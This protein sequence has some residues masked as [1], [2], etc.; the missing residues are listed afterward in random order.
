MSALPLLALNQLSS[1][2]G[3]PLVLLHA[4]PVDSRMWQAVAA[5]L[6]A[7]VRA[8]AADLPGQG[9]SPL[10]SIQTSM[11]ETAEAVYRTLKNEGIANAI[12]VGCSMGGYVAL[13]LAERHPAFVAGLGLVDTK[14]TADSADVR[15]YRLRMAREMEMGPTIAPA[16]AMYAS[17]LGETTLKERRALIPAVENWVHSQSPRGLAWA[18][19]T[20]AG[21]LD[22]TEMLRHY[23]GPVAVVLGAEDKATTVADAQVMVEAAQDVTLEVIP[24]VGHLSPVEDPAAVAAVLTGLHRRVL[25]RSAPKARP[26]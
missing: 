4:Y 9:F 11:Q 19:K 10:G 23:H 6:P 22:R 21:R 15:A 18:M 3:V 16:L 14:A 25:R 20:M 8:L 26:F 13:A 12:V 17:L 5:H 1:G 2:G 7:H 24:Q